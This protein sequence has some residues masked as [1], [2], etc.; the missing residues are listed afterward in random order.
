MYCMCDVIQCMCPHVQV[1]MYLYP[2]SFNPGA[3]NNSNGEAIFALGFPW[4]L[5]VLDNYCTVATFPSHCMLHPP[6]QS[7]HSIYTHR[8]GAFTLT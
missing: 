7:Q 8:M 5:H 6:P 3:K 4:L 1:N 2:C